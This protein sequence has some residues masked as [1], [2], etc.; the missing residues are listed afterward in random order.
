MAQA[1][2]ASSPQR[3]QRSHGD[4]RVGFVT[5]PTGARLS[6]LAQR[7]SAKAI[8]LPGPEVV[9]LNTSGGLT[10]GD[11][12]SY[13]LDVPPGARLVATTQTAERIYRASAD[14]ARIA[15]SAN[16][17][18]GAHLDWLPQETILFDRCAAIRETTIELAEG[19][20]CLMAET[21]VLGRPA[22]G[23]TVTDL[24][25]LDLRRISRA[26]RPLHLEPLRIEAA[27]LAP[28]PAGIGAARALASVVMVARGAEDALGPLRALLPFPDVRAAASGLDGR[29]ILRLM[30]A[31]AW[32][33]RKALAA[34]LTVLRRQPLPRVW[35]S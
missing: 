10:G 23:E 27:A 4:A 34:I 12:L 7:G 9:F 25:F 14:S 24:S 2:A 1:L 31:D 32:P 6:V 8:V 20:S 19:A 18:A 35:Q 30:A 28:G 3:H 17:G 21:L 5:G 13:A 15:V 29:V 16:L 11:R 33:L 26:G 22:M